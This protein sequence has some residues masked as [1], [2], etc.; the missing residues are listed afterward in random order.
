MPSFLEREQLLPTSPYMAPADQILGAFNTEQSLF[1]IGAA[2]VN[3]ASQEY[4]NMPLSNPQN[5]QQLNGLLTTANQ[6]LKSVSMTNLS[7]GANQDQALSVFSPIIKDQ[8]IM[9][10]HALTQAWGQDKQRAESSRVSSGGKG[11][12]PDSLRAVNTQQALFAKSDKSSWRTFYTIKESYNPYY[13]Q[14]GEMD[15]LSKNFKTDVI[16]KD[17]QNGA[18]IT[19]T[20]DSSWYKDKWQQYVETNASPQLKA[21]LAQ[22]ARADYYT[23][24]LTM[25]KDAMVAKYTGIRDNLI[26][27]QMDTDYGNM[28]NYGLQLAMNHPT[29][30]NA[31]KIAELM[32]KAKYLQESYDAK[33]A[34]LNTPLEGADA[35]GTIEGLA[36][37]TNIAEQLG[38]HQYFDKIGDAFA[39]REE[40]MSIKPDYAYLS[41]KRIGESAREFNIRQTETNRHDKATEL[42]LSNMEGIDMF[43]AQAD[44]I[45]AQNSGKG[46]KG[47]NGDNSDDDP[48][49]KLDAGAQ[50]AN[51]VSGQSNPDQINAQGAMILDKLNNTQIQYNQLYDDLSKQL[52]TPNLMGALNDALKDP[53]KQNYTLS[54]LPDPTKG[55]DGSG[56]NANRL[57]RFLA[58]AGN[59]RDG[60][61]NHIDNPAAAYGLTIGQINNNLREIWSD[62]AMFNKALEAAKGND[63]SVNTYSMAAELEK[64]KQRI[65]NEHAD[66]VTQAL[67]S[68]RTNLGKYAS[69]FEKDY[70]QKGKIPTAD[71]VRKVMDNVPV[72]AIQDEL[73]AGD[74]SWGDKF[75]HQ[76]GLISQDDLYRQTK[77]D[78]ITKNITS[79]LGV[80]RTAYNSYYQ[81]YM[82]DKGDAKKD[83]EFQ[84]NLLILLEGSQGQTKGQ[85]AKTQRVIDYARNHPSSVESIKMNSVDEAHN[86]P[87]MQVRF[88]EPSGP[89]EKAN[90]PETSEVEISTTNANKKFYEAPYD[91]RTTLLNNRSLKFNVQYKDGTKSNL[92]IYNASGDKDNPQFD[93]NPEFSYKTLDVDP[94]TGNIT[95]LK[96]I[97]KSDEANL[98]T[99]GRPN[100][101]PMYLSTDPTSVYNTLTNKLIKNRDAVNSYLESKG[102]IKNVRDLPEFIKN[103]LIN[104][105]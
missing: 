77:A 12:N 79:T 62:P 3:R 22:K 89:F 63:S 13:D 92:A 70:F 88:K 23:D 86:L 26:R 4:N 31:P 73:G 16:E 71:E 72:S 55:S 11:Y 35:I 54:E 93:I 5:Q 15:K 101:L 64:R 66:I 19:T 45:R 74:L 69:L 40:K 9:G 81:N 33:K 48:T 43:R 60:Q 50:P 42:H 51:R 46:K 95:G 37:G 56:G 78:Q 91:D 44:M 98:L 82:P 21:Q 8:D 34:V 1:G 105:F 41:L 97:Y 38:Q 14:A 39:H 32:A 96:T 61:G 90:L 87:W 6:Q 103:A 10:D 100:L 29:K 84:N 68:L 17:S 80:N 67:P 104:P 20:K 99:R 53:T 102:T 36:T 57:A 83:T 18:Y 47:N 49:D 25:P 75:K 85:D 65:D 76:I 52:F 24:M 59:L 94:T 27:K 7:I 30:D 2:Q 28:M 58:A